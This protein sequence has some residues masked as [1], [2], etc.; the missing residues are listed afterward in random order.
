MEPQ[1]GIKKSDIMIQLNGELDSFRNLLSFSQKWLKR[2]DEMSPDMMQEMLNFREKWITRVSN[3]KGDWV[4]LA[5]QAG[6]AYADTFIASMSG[7][8]VE[9]QDIDSQIYKRLEERK[10]DY[11]RQI[12]DLNNSVPG[13]TGRWKEHEQPGQRVDIL[14]K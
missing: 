11:L 2:I 9:L 8:L 1:T 7:V 3:R 10:Q 5:R 13:R 14:R 4:T 6:E 12:S